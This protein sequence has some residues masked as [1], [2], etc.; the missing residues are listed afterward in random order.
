MNTQTFVGALAGLFQLPPAKVTEGFKLDSDN[1]DSVVVMGAIALIDE[2][3]DIT[4]PAK[5]LVNCASVKQLLDLITIRLATV[6][7]GGN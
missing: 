3:Y 5:D 7:R 4:V 6:S 2:Q 1:W